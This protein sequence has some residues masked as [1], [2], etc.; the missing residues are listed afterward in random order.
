MIYRKFQD[1]DLSLLGFGTMRLP[2]T[3]DGEIDKALVAEMTDYAFSNGV[4]Y[5]D[6]AYPYMSSK[7]EIVMGEILKKYPRDSFYLADKFP[8][9]MLMG[10]PAPASIFEEQLKKCQVEYFDFYL[11]HNVYENSIGVYKD[12]DYGV[13]D[14]LLEQKRLGRI[15]HLGFSC[16]GN[17]ELLEDFLQFAGDKMEFCQLQFN[18]M[19]WTLQ[20]VEE[21]YRILEQYGI[22]V[23]VMEPVRGGKLA[24]LGPENNARLARFRP[25]DSPASFAFRWL[26]GKE[27]IRMILSGMSDLAQMKDNVA[28]FRQLDL[29]TPEEDAA[30]MDIA[31]ELKN[32]IPCTACRYCCD[33]CPMGLDIPDLISKLNQLRAGSG[34]TIAMQLDSFP[35]DKLPSACIGCGKCAK[36]C[37]QKIDI[38]GVMKTLT[39]EVAKLPKWS[40]QVKARNEAARKARDSM[41]I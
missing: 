3:P 35:Q 24:D 22:P 36:V 41:N 26:Q 14:Y 19:D 9:H 32:A 27:N 20:R 28:T 29:L 4:N 12:P 17:P 38:P 10:R 15:R 23:W 18:Y 21:K 11:L 30:V 7:S 40:D 39:E 16:H 37:P 34:N 25:D 5:I 8:G 31:E 33:G 6:T 1:L 13:L 2:T